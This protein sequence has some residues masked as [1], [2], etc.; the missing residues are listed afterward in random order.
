MLFRSIPKDVC[1]VGINFSGIPVPL[2]FIPTPLTLIYPTQTI[3][4]KWT[5][6]SGLGVLW[7]NN[8]GQVVNWS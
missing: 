8:S 7:S 5:N 2:P 3:V 4:Y 6:N 1:A